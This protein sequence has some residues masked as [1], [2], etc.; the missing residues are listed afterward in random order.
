MVQ[1]Y[2]SRT[3]CV[4]GTF[5]L[6]TILIQHTHP[7]TSRILSEL[8]EITKAFRQVVPSYIVKMHSSRTT[9]QSQETSAL[10]ARAPDGPHEFVE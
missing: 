2:A 1:T 8:D 6:H 3:P 7:S 4:E 9:G 5:Q 10:G